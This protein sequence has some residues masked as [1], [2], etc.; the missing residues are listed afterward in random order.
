MDKINHHL[1]DALLM[2]Y[3]SGALPEALDLVVL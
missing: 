1:T 3:A 2:G